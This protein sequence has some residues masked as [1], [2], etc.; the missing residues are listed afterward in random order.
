MTE[1][2]CDC[3][4]VTTSIIGFVLG[5]LYLIAKKLGII[6]RLLYKVIIFLCV[7]RILFL[8]FAKKN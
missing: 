4:Y 2:D 7:L 6:N 8:D 1:S 5:V 3:C